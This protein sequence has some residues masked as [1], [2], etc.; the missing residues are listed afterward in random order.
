MTEFEN[1][2]RFTSFYARF[3]TK[4]LMAYDLSFIYVYIILLYVPELVLT[5]YVLNLFIQGSVGH[6]FAVCILSCRTVSAWL[7]KIRGR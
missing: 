1:Q 3:P 4:P 2:L 5:L 6:D 7:T